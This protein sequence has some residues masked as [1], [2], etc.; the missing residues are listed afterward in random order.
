MNAYLQDI[1]CSDHLFAHSKQKYK[2]FQRSKS[3]NWME[4]V[5]EEH[6]SCG[7]G[8]SSDLGQ[9][10]QDT[11]SCEVCMGNRP[12]HYAP[13]VGGWG[14]GGLGGHLDQGEDSDEETGLILRH[15]EWHSDDKMDLYYHQW[16]PETLIYDIWS[17]FSILEYLKTQGSKMNF[18]ACKIS[19]SPMSHLAW[20]H[21]TLRCDCL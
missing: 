20:N 18:H 4:E 15:G 11:D 17:V 19:L 13:E 1:S 5:G 16:P 2:Y 14:S 3:T 6:M 21:V 7:I 12:V 9:M 10:V 8:R